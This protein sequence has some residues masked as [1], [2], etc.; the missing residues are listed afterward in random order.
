MCGGRC[1]TGPA[2]VLV[3][4]PGG[5]SRTGFFPAGTVVTVASDATWRAMTTADFAQYDVIWIDGGFC[6]GS[7]S[8][9]MGTA[10]DTLAT[11]GPAVRGRIEILTGD[12][13]LHGDAGAPAFYANSVNWLKQFGRTSD[14]GATSLFMSWGCTVCCGGG[15]T[16]GARGTIERFTSVL[17]SPIGGDTFNY[18]TS[19]SVTAAGASH[20]VMSGVSLW[21]CP[22]HGAFSSLPAGYTRLVVGNSTGNGTLAVREPAMACIP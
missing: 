1:Y 16:P 19:V 3:Y 11:W 17:G 8:S 7:P 22:F 18:C 10:D 2:R 12:P 5:S 13:D 21:G 9:L 20:P 15:Y 14:G 4:G 6:S